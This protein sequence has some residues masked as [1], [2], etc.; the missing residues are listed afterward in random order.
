MRVVQ[1]MPSWQLIIAALSLLSL[2]VAVVA[3]FV[4]AKHRAVIEA[5]LAK[6]RC[7]PLRLFDLTYGDADQVLRKKSLVVPE[8]L[9]TYDRDYLK[10]FAVAMNRAPAGDATALDLYVGVTLHWDIVFAAAL[11]LFITL[12]AF[13]AATLPLFSN[14]WAYW[15]FLFF[16]CMGAVYGAADVAEDLKLASIL[17]DWQ[18]AVEEAK[19]QPTADG[20]PAAVDID[21][22]EAAAANALTRIKLV[23]IFFSLLGV[24]VFFILNGVAWLIH[25]SSRGPASP[26]PASETT[27][28]A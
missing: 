25:G 5:I 16:A 8:R 19:L 24:V 12:C 26:M 28:S 18:C 21:G 15:V 27:R 13:D 3:F 11:G 4:A 1:T 9:W 2:I 7:K 17:K 22:G 14:W 6:P 20:H 23:A 10:D